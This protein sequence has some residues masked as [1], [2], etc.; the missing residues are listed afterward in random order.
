MFK[1][2]FGRL[3]LEVVK[4]SAIHSFQ[5]CLY[6]LIVSAI[7]FNLVLGF[8]YLQFK[9]NARHR[10][11][12]RH[13]RRYTVTLSAQLCSAAGFTICLFQPD[14]IFALFSSSIKRSMIILF[15]I[16]LFLLSCSWWKER[17][18]KFNWI[19]PCTSAHQRD[20][21]LCWKHIKGMVSF[22]PSFLEHPLQF[23]RPLVFV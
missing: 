9:P 15:G 7:S 19:K 5:N 18:R 4:D 12:A 21:Y 10:W 11:Y 23:P 1:R 6:S 16:S 2:W 3:H 8:S 20:R 17:V 13:T 14:I 22:A